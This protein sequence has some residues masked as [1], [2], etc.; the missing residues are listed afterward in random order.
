MAGAL[1]GAGP[2]GL[3]LPLL[4]GLTDPR[5]GRTHGECAGLLLESGVRLVQV[6]DK[7]PSAG[8]CLAAAREVVARGRLF[9]AIVI[10]NDRPDVA[11]LS[12]SDG[13]H[14]GE[15]DLPA[16]DARALLGA[17]AIVGVS[18]HAVESARAAMERPEASY[19]ALGPVFETGS[20]ESPH[21]PLGLAAVESAARGKTRPLVVI[22]GIVPERVGDCL[23]AGADA[24]AM[25]SGLL[26]GDVARNVEAALASAARAGFA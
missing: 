13:V 17:A 1:A 4:Y 7:G 11:L 18:T 14:L 23:A 20:K 15:D 3:R 24:V 16:E 8:A 25:I 12:G 9:G 5:G 19:V 21:R 6:R 10:V 22:G 2:V 26:D